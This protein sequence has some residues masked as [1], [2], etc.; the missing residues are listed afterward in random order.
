VTLK[1]PEIHNSH[2]L[3]A[4]TLLI[5]YWKCWSGRRDSNP[6]PSAPK[7][8]ALPGCATPRRFFTPGSS[9]ADG[10]I[11]FNP[12]RLFTSAP[13]RSRPRVSPNATIEKVH[14]GYS[15]AA[16]RLTVAQDVV[17]SIPTSR[18]NGPCRALIKPLP[19]SRSSPAQFTP[20]IPPDDRPALRAGC[21]LRFIPP[22]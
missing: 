2:Q 9:F 6:R 14:G 15:S 4:S 21:P 13:T 19:L 3:S 18:P 20:K 17:G 16:E 22:T 7:A 10:C 5:S 12:I 1:A 11:Q 8:D